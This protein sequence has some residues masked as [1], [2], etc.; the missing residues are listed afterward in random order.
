MSR[1]GMRP[2]RQ[3]VLSA[4]T[5]RR[6]H[7]W[8][9]SQLQMRTISGPRRHPFRGLRGLGGLGGV[10]LSSSRIHI[11]APQANAWA[12]A[13]SIGRR[14]G[15]SFSMTAN[16]GALWTTIGDGSELIMRSASLSGRCAAM[17]L[18]DA[19]HIQAHAA[20]DTSARSPR[21]A[22]PAADDEIVMAGHD[23]LLLLDRIMRVPMHATAL[24]RRCGVARV[25]NARSS[26]QPPSGTVFR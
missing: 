1:T 17:P 15:S 2:T 21:C 13:A 4:A 6:S 25:Q 26:A 14:W 19:F 9:H 12:N 5:R 11:G 7:R 8:L 3:E 22:V 23:A 16:S 20:P 18:T 10:G 24:T